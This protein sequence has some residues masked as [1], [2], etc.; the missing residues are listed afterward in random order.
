MT[1]HLLRRR[2]IRFDRFRQRVVEHGLIYGTPCWE[3][4]VDLDAHVH[5]VALPAPGDEHALR[6]LVEERAAPPLDPG[7]PLWQVHVVENVGPGGALVMRYH[8]CLGDGA[9]MMAVASRL[10]DMPLRTRVRPWKSLPHPWLALGALAVVAIATALPF[11][12][13]AALLGFVRPTAGMLLAIAGLALR[14]LACAEIAKQRFFAAQAHRD[15]RRPPLI[16]RNMLRRLGRRLVAV[17]LFGP[18]AKKGARP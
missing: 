3:E 10:F 17:H 13:A 14:Y 1:S 16:H 8:H 5:H 12:P 15:A 18:H 9:A 4:A 6:A 7:R 11:T 2:L